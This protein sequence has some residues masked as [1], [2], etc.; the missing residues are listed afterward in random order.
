[1]NIGGTGKCSGV[2]GGATNIPG[3]S[4][5]GSCGGGRNRGGSGACGCKERGGTGVG[6]D[7]RD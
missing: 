7:T 3:S 6:A 1:M 4:D 5:I 2:C